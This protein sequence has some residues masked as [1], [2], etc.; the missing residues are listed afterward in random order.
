MFTQ[1]IAPVCRRSTPNAS[2]YPTSA[3]GSRMP[4]QAPNATSATADGLTRWNSPPR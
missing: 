3:A 2:P 4:V 1:T